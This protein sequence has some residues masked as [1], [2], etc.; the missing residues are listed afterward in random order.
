MKLLVVCLVAVTLGISGCVSQ[1]V[2]TPEQIQKQNRADSVVANTLFD[3]N[4]TDLASYNVRPDGG[5]V[6][7]FHESVQYR[8]YNGAVQALRSSNEISSVYAEQGG[9]E[10]CPLGR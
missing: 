10:V 1:D 6:I 8:V 3:R 4:L 9:R 7:Q 5:V 2:L